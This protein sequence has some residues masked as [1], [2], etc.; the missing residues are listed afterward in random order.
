MNDEK[1]AA[2]DALL[3]SAYADLALAA[4]TQH[5][6][7]EALEDAQTALA[8]AR[9]AKIMLG[10]IQGKN[11][12]ERKASEVTVLA[13]EIDAVKFHERSLRLQTL[14]LRLAEIEAERIRWKIRLEIGSMGT[15]L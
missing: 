14:A 2:L 13:D 1:K 10:E 12:T 6:K 3:D 15:V 11:E 4:G 9:A 7:G 5:A 8:L